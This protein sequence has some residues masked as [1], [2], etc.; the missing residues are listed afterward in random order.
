[1]RKRGGK[2]STLYTTEKKTKKNKIIKEKGKQSYLSKC[3]LEIDGCLEAAMVATG[4][5]AG[6]QEKPH[7]ERD[8]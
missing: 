3:R 5:C 4:L 2:S 8:W 6:S 7:M 1:M